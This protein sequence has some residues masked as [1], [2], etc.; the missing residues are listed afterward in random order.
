MRETASGHSI[1]LDGRTPGGSTPAWAPGS[2]TCFRSDLEAPPPVSGGVEASGT[3]LSSLTYVPRHRAGWGGGQKLLACNQ[4]GVPSSTCGRAARALAATANR[5]DPCG[6]QPGA[7]Q[8]GG[9]RLVGDGVRA[10]A[11]RRSHACRVIPCHS[12]Q[13]EIRNASGSFGQRQTR[14]KAGTQSHEATAVLRERRHAGRAADKEMAH[15]A[16]FRLVRVE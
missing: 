5:P 3:D 15:A 14:R 11:S 7:T 12:R 4:L 16:A 13:V 9:G 2:C 8:S 10:I 1:P 6:M